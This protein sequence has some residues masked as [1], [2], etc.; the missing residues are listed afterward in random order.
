MIQVIFIKL[1]ILSFDHCFE[2]LKENENTTILTNKEKESFFE[3][4]GK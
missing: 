3:S 2:N 1:S 4:L